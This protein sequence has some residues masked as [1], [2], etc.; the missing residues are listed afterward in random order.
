LSTPIAPNSD[1]KIGHADIDYSIHCAGDNRDFS[2][3]PANLPL[4]ICQTRI[5]GALSW[6]ERDFIYAVS[7]ASTFAPPNFN[8]HAVSLPQGI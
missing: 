5:E 8:I 4:G 6:Y 1:S 3:D 7:S 2:I